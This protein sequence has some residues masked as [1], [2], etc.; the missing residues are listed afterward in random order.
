MALFSKD[1][2][3]WKALYDWDPQAAAVNWWADPNNGC[4]HDTIFHFCRR[5]RVCAMVEDRY[6]Y[7]YRGGAQGQ[8]QDPNQP[9]QLE[10]SKTTFCML[11]PPQPCNAEEQ[12]C[13]NGKVALKPGLAVSHELDTNGEPYVISR[14]VC[15]KSCSPGYW[16]TCL[17]SDQ[18]QKCRY[19]APTEKMIFGEVDKDRGVAKWI[20]QNRLA[21]NGVLP[22]AMQIR[23]GLL[24]DECYP[25]LYANGLSHYGETMLL[26][27]S[28]LVKKG[29]LDFYCPGGDQPPVAC[30]QGQV[31]N[32]DS[33]TNS[34]GPCD[35]MDGYYRDGA[36]CRLCPA[37]SY[38]L[39][40]RGIVACP[41]DTYSLAGASVCLPCG[42]DSGACGPAQALIRCMGAKWQTQNA[43]CVDCQNCMFSGGKG[44]VPCQRV[45]T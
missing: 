15:P 35:C 12:S 8:V 34:S 22:V 41:T 45:S 29:Y 44:G 10:S 9:K 39:F 31:S 3:I 30:P 37:G 24:I 17:N 25:C 21:G 43:Y 16:L 13:P 26:A 6:G 28:Q 5:A 23:F 14:A 11:C 33:K 20:Q 40:E 7:Y 27:D 32:I 18:K 1:F 38:C 2:N 4:A 19:Q 42:T 36:T